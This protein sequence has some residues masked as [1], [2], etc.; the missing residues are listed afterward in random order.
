[1]IA[2]GEAWLDPFCSWPGGYK[3]SKPEEYFTSLGGSADWWSLDLM[4]THGNIVVLFDF[5][6][7]QSVGCFTYW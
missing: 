2:V 5:R 1:M 7:S 3:S 4:I 6:K